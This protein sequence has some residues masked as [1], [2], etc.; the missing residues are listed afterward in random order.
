MFKIIVTFLFYLININFSMAA[1]D[2]FQ[3]YFASIKSSQVNL[4]TG[5]NLRYPIK[6]TFL[7]SGEPVEVVAKFDA[8]RK[9]IDQTGEE[10]WIHLS[11]ISNKRLAVV[12]GNKLINMYKNND[13]NSRIIAKFEPEVR[14]KLNKCHN[15]WCLVE[16]NKIKGYISRNNLWGVYNNEEF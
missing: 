9:I 11:M 1:E 10:G 8:W 16:Y 12:I 5:P 14:V 4:R 2:K 6:W 15:E 3:P 7:K 13:L